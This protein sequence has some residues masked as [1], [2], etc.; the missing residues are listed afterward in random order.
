MPD[1][2]QAKRKACCFG[3]TGS[4]LDC[5][6]RTETTRR[7]ALSLVAIGFDG[8]RLRG[9]HLHRPILLDYIDQSGSTW[10]FSY[11]IRSWTGYS[12]DASHEQERKLHECI[13][14]QSAVGSKRDSD[15]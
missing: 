13:V 14:A 11:S 1:V 3:L 2:I 9:I 10:F 12:S 5:S 6:E 15:G 4:H 8:Q 7:S